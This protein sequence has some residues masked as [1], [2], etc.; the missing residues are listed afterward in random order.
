MSERSTGWRYL[1]RKMV[2]QTSAAVVLIVLSYWMPPGAQAMAR[3][4]GWGG[5]VLALSWWLARQ[6]RRQPGDE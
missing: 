2:V 4:T 1:P 5:V 3:E 6:G